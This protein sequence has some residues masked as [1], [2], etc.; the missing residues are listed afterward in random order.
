MFAEHFLFT[1]SYKTITYPSSGLANSL[2]KY[3]LNL[4]N[5]EKI[6]ILN[7]SIFPTARLQEIEIFQIYPM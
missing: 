1:Q 4:V 7:N 6:K 5:G 3:M 2:A